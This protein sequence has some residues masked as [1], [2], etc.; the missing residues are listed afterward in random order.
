MRTVTAAQLQTARYSYE[1]AKKL[2]EKAVAA[3]DAEAP[4]LLLRM[5]AAHAAYMARL[6]EW[7]ATNVAGLESEKQ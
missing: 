5:T 2:Y 3:N 6:D 1:S 7:I 4:I